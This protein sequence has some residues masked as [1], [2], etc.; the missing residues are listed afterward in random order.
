MT[1]VVAL[2]LPRF[3]LDESEEKELIKRLTVK[4]AYDEVSAIPKLVE[5]N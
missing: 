4:R 3:E 1:F 5:D 2:F